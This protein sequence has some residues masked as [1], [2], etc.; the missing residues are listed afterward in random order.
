M[1][2]LSLFILYSSPTQPFEYKGSCKQMQHATA[3]RHSK[4]WATDFERRVEPNQ[5]YDLHTLMTRLRTFT[6]MSVKL[7]YVIMMAEIFYVVSNKR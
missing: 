5:N 3:A 4:N 1:N 6:M 7:R 2:I